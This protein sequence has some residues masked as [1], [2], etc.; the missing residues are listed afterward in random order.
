MTDG[1]MHPFASLTVSIVSASWECTQ[2]L[3]PYLR[4]VRQ[5]EKHPEAQ[6]AYIH[7]TYLCYFFRLLGLLAFSAGLDRTAFLRLKETLLN[8]IVPAQVQTFFGDPPDK[9]ELQSICYQTLSEAETKD[10]KSAQTLA[11]NLDK[12]GFDLARDVL[13]LAGYEVGNGRMDPDTSKALNL[14]VDQVRGIRNERRFT[15]FEESLRLANLAVEFCDKN[16][17]SILDASK[18]APV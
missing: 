2:Q 3:R 18:A 13:V 8:M 11:Q 6:E 17:I 1:L 12:I 10:K 5:M 9:Q 14:I 7:F 15:Q 16:G 4:P